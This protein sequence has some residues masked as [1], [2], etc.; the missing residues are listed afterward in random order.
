MTADV[1]N[2]CTVHHNATSKA[3][4]TLPGGGK[5]FS[6]RKKSA[7]A[8]VVCRPNTGQV[9]SHRIQPPE[10][11]VHEKAEP[12]QRP[13]KVRRGCVNKEEVLEAF[14]NEPP[15]TNQGVAQDERSI[16]PDKPVALRRP[17]NEK[18]CRDDDADCGDALEDF[19][20]G[21]D[22]K[23]LSLIKCMVLIVATAARGA[24]LEAIQQLV[25][26]VA[27]GWDAKNGRLQCLERDGA[28]WKPAFPAWPVLYGKNGLAWGR[29]VRGTDEAGLHKGEHDGRAPAGVFSD[30]KNLY[31]RRGVAG[32]GKLSLSHGHPR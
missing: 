30:R 20:A 10:R 24:E 26:S 4:R 1:C 5:S 7:S 9:I 8:A 13:I 28:G 23:K 2:G 21:D 22:G 11:V 18:S 15:A 12:L 19:Q 17:V 27:P 25:V 3:Q 16:I 29:G 32:R 6:T 31:L 14:R